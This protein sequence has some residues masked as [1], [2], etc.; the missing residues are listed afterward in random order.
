MEDERTLYP[1]FGGLNRIAMIWGVP[2][3]PALIV[4]CSSLMASMFGGFVLGPGGLLIGTAGVPVFLFL[5]HIC[6]TDDQALR[7]FWLEFRC[8]LER[9]IVSVFG[10]THTLAPM[11]YGR[12]L[13]VYT[14]SFCHGQ[15][16]ERFDA[17]CERLLVPMED[18]CDE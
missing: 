5:R 17:L 9:R 14:R 3:F 16:L 4:A 12:S 10:K 13:E 1:S 2:L 7:L 8:W 15:D 6:E 11:R 18:D